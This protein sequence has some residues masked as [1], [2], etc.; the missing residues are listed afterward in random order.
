ML[1]G[2]ITAIGLKL[3]RCCQTLQTNSMQIIENWNK[4][5]DLH[6]IKTENFLNENNS[7][8]IKY[9]KSKKDRSEIGFNVFTLA[10][11][12]YYRENFHSFIFASF[13][14]PQEKHLEGDKYL[15]LFVDLLN[16]KNNQLNIEKNDFLNSQVHIEKHKIDILITDESSKKAIIIENKINNAVDQFRQ[17]PNYVNKIKNEYDVVAVVYLTLNSEKR[18]DKNDWTLTER[19]I[20]DKY[21]KLIPV[22][23]TNSK[24]V[25]LYNDW[26]I[27]S[28]I[29]SQNINSSSIL[30][31]YGELIKY[32]NTN[33]MD[34]I[35]LKKFHETIQN[36]NNLETAI[37][38]RNMLNDLPQY[39]AIRI[40]EKYKSSCFPFAKI[41]RY[42]AVDTVFEG[43]EIGEN[44]FK[45]DIWC[46]EDK[47]IVYFWEVKNS[48]FEIRKFC[49]Q[50]INSVSDFNIVGNELNKISK[51][52]ST[53]NEKMLFDFID[54]LLIELKILK[55]N[56]K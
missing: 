47:Y 1:F 14:N 37:S 9:K 12:F 36:N 54:Q 17:L 53:L 52:F 48:D 43:F 10:S 25:N 44:Y 49:D 41:W 24:T 4:I 28:I 56:E 3:Y 5:L 39:L 15:H 42:K 19:Q 6:N 13:L 2:R 45:M 33:T 20:I 7:L 38:I 27:P 23:D 21:L 34:T 30:R 50:K 18:P 32:L 22:F 46:S 11:D 35:A 40:E 26:I 8:S 51:E 29:I 31:Q 55:N 16:K